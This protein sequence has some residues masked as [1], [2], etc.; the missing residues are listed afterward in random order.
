VGRKTT[1]P[2]TIFPKPACRTADALFRLCG[3]L[4][5]EQTA[6]VLAACGLTDLADL[7]RF[8]N[9]SICHL[10]PPIGRRDSAQTLLGQ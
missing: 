2:W 7:V 10:G 1:L 6:A 9:T 5:Q 8:S 4:T 3:G